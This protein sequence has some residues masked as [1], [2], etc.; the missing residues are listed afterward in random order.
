MIVSK[1]QAYNQKNINLFGS[2]VEFEKYKGFKQV[3][4]SML[5]YLSI[6]RKRTRN[7]RLCKKITKVKAP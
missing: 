2:C 4:S 3:K 1:N 7:R 5:F 6:E